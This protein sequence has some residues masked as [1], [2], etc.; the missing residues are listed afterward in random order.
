MKT[1]VSNLLNFLELDW[2]DELENYQQ[3]ALNRGIISTPS[4][5]QVVQPLYKTASNRWVK[6]QDSLKKYF[7]KI[8]KWTTKFGYE[9]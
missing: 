1:E 2:E 7:I 9:L 8:E 4:Y 5:S 6:Y 3:T